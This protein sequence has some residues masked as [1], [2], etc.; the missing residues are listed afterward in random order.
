MA[1]VVIAIGGDQEI[2]AAI[3]QDAAELD[4]GALR[5][6]SIRFCSR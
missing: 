1:T 6:M 4:C 3:T 2:T 5:P